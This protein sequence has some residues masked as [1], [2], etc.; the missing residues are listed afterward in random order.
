MESNPNPNLIPE[1]AID[2]IY[3]VFLFS[4]WEYDQAGIANLECAKLDIY[5]MR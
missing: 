2:P 3:R 1:M 4:N 5:A